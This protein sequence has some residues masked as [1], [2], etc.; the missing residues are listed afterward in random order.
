MTLKEH[1]DDM[2]SDLERGV[3]VNEASVSQGIVLRLLHAL[4]WPGYNTQ[5]IIPEYSVEGR[6][7]DFALCHPSLKPLVFIEVKQVGQIEGAERQLFEYAF[8]TGVPIAILTDGREWH[9][10]QPGGRGDYRERRVYKLNLIETEN[11]EISLRLNRY[12]NYE[13]ICTGE[14]ITAIEDDYRTISK[15]RHIETSLPE[16]WIKLV[17][18]ADEFLIDVMAEKTESLCGYKPTSGQ[19]L[20]FLK[21]LK[22]EKSLEETHSPIPLSPMPPIPSSSTKGPRGFDQIQA[23]IQ[24]MRKGKSHTE[25]FR[26]VA[27]KLGVG[28]QTVQSRCT[29]TLE[30]STREFVEHVRSGWIIQIIKNKYPQQIELINELERSQ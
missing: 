5:V 13:L 21:D 18:E 24:L 2:R 30:L 12:L 15:Q 4:G 23:V 22:R 3:F 6:R 16:A 17:E 26:S 27:K 9:F 11:E 10:F 1:L 25:A 7:V 29:R 14:A 8:H 28:Y 20:G 19:V